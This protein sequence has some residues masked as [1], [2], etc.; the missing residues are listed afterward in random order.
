[1]G[2]ADS[3]TYLDQKDLAQA[4]Q[5]VIHSAYQIEGIALRDSQ[6]QRNPHCWSSSRGMRTGYLDAVAVEDGSMGCG[7][8][9]HVWTWHH[10]WVP[11][12]MVSRLL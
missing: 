4:R 12:I 7:V 1:M 8:L 9:F 2:H 3:E 10:S 5:L 11:S 6:A